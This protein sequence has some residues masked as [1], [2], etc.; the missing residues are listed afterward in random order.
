MDRL[1]ESAV[2][3]I[4]SAGRHMGRDRYQEGRVVLVGKHT[5]K[6]RGHFYVYQKQ[7]DGSEVRR[8]RNIPLG[9]KSE[10]DKGE[11]KAKLREIIARETKDVAPTPVNVTL[12]WFYENRFLPQKEQ[13]WKVTSRP[14]T[15]RFIENYLL[16]RFGDALLGDLDKF[17]LQT[18]LNEMAPRYSK[19][20][21]S[22]IR[23]YFNSILDEAVEL[24]MLPKN[25]AGRLAVP[26]SGKRR[27]TKHLTPEEIP[28]ILFHLS[29]RDRL[30]VRMF[31]VLGL[32]PGEMFALR[33]NDK[34]A[35]SLR[36]DSSITDG[37]EVE[38]KTEG[39]DSFV[40]IPASI[41]TELEFW[42]GTA[43]S[44]DPNAFIFP[45]SRGTP[46]NTNNF[47]F[48]VLKEAG[49]TAGIDGVTHQMLRRTCSTYMAQITSVKDVQAHLRHTNAKTTLEH[50]IKS[51]PESVRVAVESLDQLLK[52]KPSGSETQ[53]N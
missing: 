30:I 36:I 25:P 23:V 31:L 43:T 4:L 5:K 24:E 34:Q 22:K 9:L 29:D 14:K 1:D 33:W 39:S 16:K 10:M 20:V 50:Y 19:S 15:K 26:K 41:D 45:S 12:R 46:I 47:L 42:R 3:S 2:K 17:T 28:Q 52:K 48:R 40:W 6:W 53:A 13:Q 27:A 21:L 38:T 18:Y 51:V 44:P 35:N 7:T 32:R 49:R 11:A 8:H 37:V